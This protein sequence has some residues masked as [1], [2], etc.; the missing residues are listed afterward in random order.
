MQ[1]LPKSIKQKLPALYAQ[2]SQKDPT[3][4]IKYFDPTGSWTWYV[5]EGSPVDANGYHD[6]DKEKVDFLFFGYVI[7]TEPELGYFSL[8]QLETAKQGTEDFKSLPIERDLSFTP[9]KL[10]EI[11]RGL[12]KQGFW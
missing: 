11:K 8:K 12:R 4:Q 6:T 5:L 9:C 7:G 10:S 2:E 1:L 3:V